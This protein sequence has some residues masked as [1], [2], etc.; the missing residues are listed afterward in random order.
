MTVEFKKL[1][2][3]EDNFTYDINIDEVHP[4]E[5]FKRLNE[6]FE[7]HLEKIEKRGKHPNYGS[8]IFE[9]FC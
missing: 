4:N 6:L 5:A 2:E 7:S 9:W 8:N 3:S 1:I